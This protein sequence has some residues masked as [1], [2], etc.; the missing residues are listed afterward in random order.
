MQITITHVKPGVVDTVH[1]LSV[2]ILRWE[3]IIDSLESYVPCSLLY[4]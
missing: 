2:P 1:N 4:T 3:R